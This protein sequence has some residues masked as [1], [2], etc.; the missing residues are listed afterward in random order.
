M[1]PDNIQE[2]YQEALD[3]EQ[4]LMKSSQGR[5]APIDDTVS[6]EV[7]QQIIGNERIRS[8]RAFWGLSLLFILLL[9]IVVVVV[10]VVQLTTVKDLNDVKNIATVAKE[11]QHK[12]EEQQRKISTHVES[13]SSTSAQ[14]SSVVQAAEAERKYEKSQLRRD[15]E[16]F[17]AYHDANTTKLAA[18]LEETLQKLHDLEAKTHSEE[19]AVSLQNQVSSQSTN[20]ASSSPAEETHVLYKAEPLKNGEKNPGLQASVAEEPEVQNPSPAISNASGDGLSNNE[21]SLSVEQAVERA[22]SVVSFSSPDIPL[23]AGQ[24]MGERKDGQRHGK[25]VYRYSNGDVYDGEFVNDKRHGFGAM[26]FVN[27]DHYI[28]QFSEDRQQGEGWLKYNTGDEYKGGFE[29][30]KRHGYGI[31]TYAD[32]SR[33]AGD[34]YEGERYGKGVYDYASGA[35]YEGYFKHG[36]M[37]GQGAY[38][39]PDGTRIEGIWQEGIIQE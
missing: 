5:L 17:S 29:N 1:A 20:Q 28:G 19:M 25:G 30:N 22:K 16:S 8:R 33:Y 34:F 7:V 4:S 2:E 10:L 13:L 3:Y 6:F 14:I 27:G 32:G 31:Y 37:H 23:E 21:S 24:Y 12:L 35:R 26:H 39:F 18:M 11:G 36:K 9:M 38:T 15:L